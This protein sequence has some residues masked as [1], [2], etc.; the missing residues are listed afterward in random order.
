M[1]LRGDE[2]RVKERAAQREI[3]VAEREK[4][5]LIVEPKREF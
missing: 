1:P 5:A 4:F 3:G 2:T